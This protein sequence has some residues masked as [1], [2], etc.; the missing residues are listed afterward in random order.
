MQYAPAADQRNAAVV[1]LRCGNRHCMGVL[2]SNTVVLSARHFL[3]G[4]PSTATPPTSGK[5]ALPRIIVERSCMLGAASTRPSRS[6][7]VR[8]SPI[9][10]S[11]TSDLVLLRLDEPIDAPRYPRLGGPLLPGV[12][13]DMPSQKGWLRGRCLF[14]WPIHIARNMR[15]IAIPSATV[16]HNRKAIKG[17]SGAPVLRGWEVV[18]IQSMITDPFGINLGLATTALTWPHTTKLSYILEATRYGHPGGLQP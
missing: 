17:D 15:T 12:R 8:A 4:L 16:V 5:D 7:K 14:V 13:I 1:T 2:L 18:G 3:R 6:K 11:A 9:P 10:N